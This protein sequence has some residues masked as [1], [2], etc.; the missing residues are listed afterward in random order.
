MREW[1]IH[2]GLICIPLVAVYLHIPPPQLSAALQKWHSAGEVFHFR[3]REI[4]YRGDYLLTHE[5]PNMT[6]YLCIFLFLSLHHASLI[7]Y[8]S[9]YLLP[10]VSYIFPPQTRLLRCFGKLRCR[11]SSPWLPHLQLRLE[12]G[13]HCTRPVANK[14]LVIIFSETKF[15][16][17]LAD[18]GPAHPA[19]PSS[20]CSGLPG[21]WLQ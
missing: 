17:V 8:S 5:L 19:L 2:V 3:G 14:H 4:F 21:F 16:F 10:C 15:V 6:L 13:T 7:I 18:L 12:Q 20:H 1:W 9:M 11:H